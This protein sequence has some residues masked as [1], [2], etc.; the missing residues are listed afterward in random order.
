MGEVTVD[1]T[2]AFLARFGGGAVGV[3]EATRFATGRKNAI[4]IEINGSAGSLAFDFED[5]NVLELFD[6][7]EPGETA[8]FRRILVTEPGSPV[9]RCT[10]GRPATAWATSTASPTR[11]STW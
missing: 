9:R 6:A 2:A 1:D 10:G 4:R 3:F 8:G 5:M 7:G 11:W